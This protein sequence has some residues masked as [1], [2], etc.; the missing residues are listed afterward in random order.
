MN[1]LKAQLIR[2]MQTEL[3]ELKNELLRLP[4]EEIL[5]RAYEYAM[6]TEIIF[7]AHNSEL[8]KH[9]MQA[10]ANHP[11]PLSDVYNKYLKHDESSLSEELENCLVEE[12]NVEMR[13]EKY[14]DAF[15]LTTIES[16]LYGCTIIPTV[17]LEVSM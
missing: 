2:T 9:Q 8:E 5:G 13:H 15:L 1:E 10:L 11:S 3:D 17:Q 14:S 16:G 7:A 12:S 6:K 4:Q